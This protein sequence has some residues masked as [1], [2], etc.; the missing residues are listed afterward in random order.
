[1]FYKFDCARYLVN[2]SDCCNQETGL[3][4]WEDIKEHTQ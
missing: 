1:M 4:P 3:V 2:K